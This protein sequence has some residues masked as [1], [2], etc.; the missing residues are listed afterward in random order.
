VSVPQVEAGL[1]A[2]GFLQ[3]AGHPLQWRLLQEL[4]RSD[5]RVTELTGLLGE[6]QNLVPYHLGKLRSARLVSARRS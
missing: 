2:G 6:P 5:R 4:A 1:D 3:L